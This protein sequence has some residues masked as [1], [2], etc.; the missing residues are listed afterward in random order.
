[1]VSGRS[2]ACRRVDLRP[3]TRGERAAE[4]LTMIVDADC[5]ISPLKEGVN[6]T[7]EELLRR[8]DRAGVDKALVWLAPPYKRELDESNAYIYKAVQ[9]HPG[10]LLGFGWADPRLGVQKAREM[11]RKCILQYGFHGVKLNGAQNDFFVDDP[12][13]SLPLIEEIAKT[14]KLLAFHCG[15]D[16]YEKTHPFRIARI[17]R[18]FP[19]TQILCVHMGGVGFPDLSGAMIEMAQECPNL[20]LI[21]S[22]VLH[23]SVLNAL[24]TLG[25]GRVS[26]GSD[27]P[28]ALM[29]V[30][31][32]AYHALLEGEVTPEEKARVMGGNLLR[33]LGLPG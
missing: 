30:C 26:F 33:L 2:A 17:A 23:T 8:M 4:E 25:A 27:T 5:H 24:K 22:M 31:V 16:A 3:Q 18:Q 29:H 7:V 10:R 32:A 15:V 19:E 11:A 14:G 12:K 28:F 6:I 9:S 1:M 13:L 21:G 20:H